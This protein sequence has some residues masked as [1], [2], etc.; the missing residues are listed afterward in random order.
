MT[1]LNQFAAT[2]I[3]LIIKKKTFPGTQNSNVQ[4]LDKS[5]IE[6]GFRIW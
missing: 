3:H 1:T 2:K 6:T 5:H 4:G